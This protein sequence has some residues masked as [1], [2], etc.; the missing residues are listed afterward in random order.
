M[1]SM[2]YQQPSQMY[3]GY[4]PQAPYAQAPQQMFQSQQRQAP[5]PP[6][7][8]EPDADADADPDVASGQPSYN[9]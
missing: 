2:Q 1:E 3:A 8:D 7:N 4:P 5:I 9:Q 6:T